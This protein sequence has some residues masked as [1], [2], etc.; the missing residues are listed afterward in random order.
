MIIHSSE[1]ELT[2]RHRLSTIGGWAH[3]HHT[4][5]ATMNPKSECCNYYNKHEDGQC[6][7]DTT[8][9]RWTTTF[10]TNVHLLRLRELGLQATVCTDWSYNN[11]LRWKTVSPFNKSNIYEVMRNYALSNLLII[12]D[13]QQDYK[14]IEQMQMFIPVALLYWVQSWVLFKRPKHVQYG[15]KN[16]AEYTDKSNADYTT[17]CNFKSGASNITKNTIPNGITTDFSIMSN[18]STLIID[19]SKWTS[20]WSPSNQYLPQSN[21]RFVTGSATPFT[22]CIITI[23]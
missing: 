3:V 4:G 13:H 12:D 20:E 18:T 11:G 22:R 16:N 15:S 14:L 6:L 17:S 8:E 5:Q 7:T 19:H 10:H 9:Q 2:P 23:P 1:T 21:P